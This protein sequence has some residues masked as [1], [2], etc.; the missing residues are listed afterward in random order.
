MVRIVASDSGGNP[1][2]LALTGFK[3]SASFLV[4]NTPPSLTAI[5]DHGRI[6]VVVRDDA[7]PVRKLEMSVD[8]G[9]WEEVRPVD[10][11]ADSLEESYEISLPPG[12]PGAPSRIVVLRAADSLGNVSTARVDVP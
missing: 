7:S 10:G 6:R 8:A 12:K 11:I 2:A 4:D 5:L 9:R 3:D 1:P